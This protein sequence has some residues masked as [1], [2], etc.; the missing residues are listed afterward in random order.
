M[1]RECASAI[2][3]DDAAAATLEDRERACGLY[4]EALTALDAM[5]RSAWPAQQTG[6]LFADITRLDEAE[7]TWLTHQIDDPFAQVMALSGVAAVIARREPSAARDLLARADPLRRSIGSGKAEQFQWQQLAE[8]AI[9]WA[10]ARIDLNEGIALG[11]D[12]DKALLR[13]GLEAEP[14]VAVDLAAQASSEVAD[15]LLASAA[16]QTSLTDT[17][18]ALV[19]AKRVHD[20]TLRRRTLTTIGHHASSES[21]KDL[22]DILTA[23]IGAAEEEYDAPAALAELS[24]EIQAQLP[25]RLPEIVDRALRRADDSDPSYASIAYGR[26]AALAARNGDQTTAKQ[27]LRDTARIYRGPVYD[28]WVGPAVRAILV[29]LASYDWKAAVELAKGWPS[30][31]R[32]PA[33]AGIAGPTAVID[34]DAAYELVDSLSDTDGW[35]I[36]AKAAMVEALVS[37]GLN[38]QDPV[39]WELSRECTSFP[40]PEVAIAVSR[41]AAGLADRD[42]DA[43]VRLLRPVLDE[44]DLAPSDVGRAVAA[45][46]RADPTWTDRLL[47]RAVKAMPPGAGLESDDIIDLL[48][49]VATAA[50][51]LALTCVQQLNDERARYSDGFAIGSPRLLGAAAVGVADTDPP[52]AAEYVAQLLVEAQLPSDRVPDPSDRIIAALFT[53]LKIDPA[54]V[55]LLVSTLL[56]RLA[57]EPV[58]TRGMHLANLAEVLLDAGYADREFLTDAIELLRKPAQGETR[59]D[60]VRAI[61]KALDLTPDVE[62]LFRL[63]EVMR[64]TGDLLLSSLPMVLPL[65]SRNTPKKPAEA[66]ADMHQRVFQ[67]AQTIDQLF[68]G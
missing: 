25:D 31:I 24:L 2:V 62:P 14:A 37:T 66:L 20:P 63:L 7:A 3:G 41:A 22:D 38:V 60:L 49:P 19:L 54:Q 4:V 68:L 26:L 27:Y 1:L 48:V 9:A 11:G 44:A 13:I 40:H 45:I 36:K 23:A 61:A 47:M 35:R 64:D 29:P 58:T 8:A 56:D 57:A 43:A 65:I 30:E 52:K 39:L 42:P 17:Q 55:D 16:E 51:T 10:T 18:S 6:E 5:P 28:A 32:D 21:P 59:L 34:P 46:H 50:P 12:N 67:T 15:L 33:L 53:A